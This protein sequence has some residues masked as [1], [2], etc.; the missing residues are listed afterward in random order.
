MHLGIELVS[1]GCAGL[2]AYLLCLVSFSS[3]PIT[4]CAMTD[5]VGLHLYA[6]C[7]RFVLPDSLMSG[8]PGQLN[9]SE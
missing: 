8:G 5:Q 9:E 6:P 1:L 2:F 3:V 4:K 7:N